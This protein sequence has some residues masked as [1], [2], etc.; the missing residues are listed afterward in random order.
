MKCLPFEST[1][2]RISWQVFK[3]LIFLSV[4]SK[5][6][7]ANITAW[8]WCPVTTF[9][10]HLCCFMLCLDQTQVKQYYHHILKIVYRNRPI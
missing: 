1:V 2:M 7:K 10:M 8:P 6:E 3:S 4:L 5:E 9:T